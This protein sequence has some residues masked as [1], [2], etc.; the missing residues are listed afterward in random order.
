M[1]PFLNKIWSFTFYVNSSS[2]VILQLNH[3]SNTVPPIPI[4]WEKKVEQILKENDQVAF[5]R[6]L[7]FKLSVPS[8]QDHHSSV[9]RLG[10]VLRLCPSWSHNM[11]CTFLPSL[12]PWH[13]S[14]PFPAVVHLIPDSCWDRATFLSYQ[15]GVREDPSSFFRIRPWS[16]IFQRR[17]N[18]SIAPK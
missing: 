3:S 11:H 14:W 1:G 7:Q 18:K 15:S 6:M 4:T 12:L 17:E 2:M 16:S 13:G 9:S 10:H 8:P 5:R